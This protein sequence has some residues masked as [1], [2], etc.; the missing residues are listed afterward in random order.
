ME[1]EVHYKID[2]KTGKES[3]EP[4]TY[5]YLISELEINN[6][7][8]RIENNLVQAKDIPS[9]YSFG[10]SKS[11][12]YPRRDFQKDFPNW[13]LK[14][15]FDYFIINEDFRKMNP[16]KYFKNGDNYYFIDDPRGGVVTTFYQ[17]YNVNKVFSEIDD[18]GEDIKFVYFE[19]MIIESTPKNT[20]FDLELEE[21]LEKM[22]NSDM[23]NRKIAMKVLEAIDL[24]KYGDEL[25]F[26]L[27]RNYDL[28]SGIP[29]DVKTNYIWRYL[30]RKYNLRS[31][32]YGLQDCLKY[33]LRFIEVSKDENLIKR[34][35]K[36][37]FDMYPISDN[38]IDF[39][40]VINTP[41]K[42]KWESIEKS[43]EL[44]NIS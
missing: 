25:S 26:F 41:D 42:E 37:A 7:I 27:F 35:N 5:N 14:R 40:L 24:N 34:V 44:E 30:S 8:K 28:V 22:I 36:Y 6:S 20:E 23:D 31:P 17:S 43:Y 10:F 13:L 19:D 2:A 12:A 39:Q 15:N 21:T 3:W 29:R 18:L 38:E 11:V 16:V 1:I 4:V 33:L 32:S 9:G